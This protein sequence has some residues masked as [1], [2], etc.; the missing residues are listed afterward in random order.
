MKYKLLYPLFVTVLQSAEGK[1]TKT[2][3]DEGRFENLFF[4]ALAADIEVFKTGVL[5]FFSEDWCV[6]KCFVS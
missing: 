4:V 5:Q 6:C 2:T 1:L 3:V